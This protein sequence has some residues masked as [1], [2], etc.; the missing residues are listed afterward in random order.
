MLARRMGRICLTVTL[1]VLLLM[2][3]MVAGQGKSPLAAARNRMV[4]EEIVGEGVTNPRVIAAIRGT[5]RHEF[6]PLLQRKNA[7]YDMALPIGEAQTISPPFVVAL[8]TEQIDPQPHDKVLE[9]GTGSGYQAAVL[10]GLVKEVYSIEIVPALGRQAKETLHRLGYTNIFCK[11]GDGY[12]GWLEH[13]PFDKIIVTCSP[14]HVPEPLVQQLKE[15]GRMVIPVGERY[16]QTL[17]LLKKVQGK[18]VTETLRPTLFVPMTGKAE[19]DRKILPDPTRPELRNGDFEEVAGDPPHITGWHYQRQM[20]LVTD[21]KAPSGK[22]YVIFRNTTAGRSSQAL[23]GFA[24]DGRKIKQLEV[25]L[26]VKGEDLR[27]GQKSTHSAR[28]YMSFYDE[29]RA[30]VGEAILGPWQGTFPW[31]TESKPVPVPPRAR[32]CIIAL[33][34]LGGIGELSVDDV[35]VRAVK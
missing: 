19:Q 3:Q 8:M 30:T 12:Q 5:P 28:L 13:A 34:L 16:Q 18:L 20:D 22:N 25:S 4:D 29:H 6:V 35:R 31:Q 2:P 14:D 32:E 21:G 10:S 17:Y 24:V 33:G 26:K 15:G 11:I 9:I 1:G 23:Q 7:Y 27:G